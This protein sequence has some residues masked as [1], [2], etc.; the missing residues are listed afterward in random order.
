MTV[1]TVASV[2]SNATVCNHGV[3]VAGLQ[4]PDPKLPVSVAKAGDDGVAITGDGGSATA[5]KRGIAIGRKNSTAFVETDGV[6]Y[7]TD[8]GEAKS[9]AGSVSHVAGYRGKAS[10]GNGVAYCVHGDLATAEVGGTALVYVGRAEAGERGLAS[11]RTVG[12][13]H[14]STGGVAIL[15]AQPDRLDDDRI[16]KRLALLVPTASGEQGGV[17]ISFVS[18][19]I[20]GERRPVIGVVGDFKPLP[21]LQVSLKPNVSYKV[22]P[23][24]GMFVE[25]PRK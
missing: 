18:D 12:S 5:G 16:G 20:T 7:V 1:V 17:L 24:T 6:A 13:A 4:R 3:A 25:Q 14:V 23:A 19:A 10:T 2:G 8:D 21:T 11:V 22:D 9:A 15:W